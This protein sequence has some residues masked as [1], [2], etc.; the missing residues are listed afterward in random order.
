[1]H[2]NTTASQVLTI[3]ERYNIRFRIEGKKIIVMP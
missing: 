2:R 1:M 3:L